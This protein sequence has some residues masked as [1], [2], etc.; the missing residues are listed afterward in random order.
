MFDYLPKINNLVVVK[1]LRVL[2]KSDRRKLPLVIGLQIV[3]ALA[4]LV[5]VGFVGVIVALSV[6]GI[7]SSSPQPIISNLLTFF[8]INELSLQYQAAI[9]GTFAATL[10]V[11]R[12]LA[13]VI[14][15]RRTLFYLSNRGAG[16]S[17]EIFARLTAQSFT[18]L[19]EIPIQEAIYAVTGGTSAITLGVLSACLSLFA[20]AVVAVVIIFG[21][22]FLNAIMA[23]SMLIFFGLT[24]GLLYKL[25]AH[26][27]HK[28]GILQASQS[29]AVNGIVTEA[30]VSYRELVVRNRRD[31]YS[32]KLQGNRLDS[33][34]VYARLQF[35]PNISKYLIEVLIVIGALF[36]SAYEFLAQDA[37][38]AIAILAVFLASATRIAPAIMRIQQSAISIKGAVGGAERTLNVIEQLKDVDFLPAT[39]DFP[40]YDHHE[41]TPSVSLDS[42]CFKYP[43]H[44]VPILDKVSIQ[45]H[46]GSFVAVVGPSGAGK[47][48]LIDLILGIVN[49]NLGNVRISNL[50]PLEAISRW[51]GAVAYV[52]QDVLIING[53][54][55]DNVA[56]GFPLENVA[57]DR[58]KAALDFAEMG[59]FVSELPA[60]ENSQVGERGVSIS[61]GQRQRLGIARAVLTQPK[62]LVLDEATSTLDAQTELSITK[63]INKLRGETTILMIAHRLSTVA[64]A[65][66][67][68]YL[69]GGEIKASGTMEEVRAQVPDFDTQAKLMGL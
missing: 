64:Q 38:A 61:G 17:S 24:A 19:K 65:D 13:S 33:A 22:F 1:C 7:Q 66:V 60:R 6:S 47:T 51:P 14:I 37:N 4:D 45:I 8:Q 30:L 43:E 54:I 27:S 23:L 36:V 11:S 46:P 10:L 34:D 39:S 32:R 18:Q 52:P 58:I 25:M 67:V 16:I 15:T 57:T 41:F 48:T 29:V 12:T 63:T 21:L 5:A 42:V 35:L 28:L 55:A 50:P 20:D 68:I 53:T 9:L 69:D 44:N 40:E 2:P 31:Y 49:P 62:L 59:K 3:L 56:F 26:H